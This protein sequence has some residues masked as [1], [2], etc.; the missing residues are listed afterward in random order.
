MRIK[1]PQPF[2]PQKQYNPSER[3]VYRGMVII[4]EAWNKKYLLRCHLCVI[5]ARE[6]FGHGCVCDEYHRTDKKRIYFRKL[7][8][9]KEKSDGKKRIYS[10]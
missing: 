5:Q 1:K 8:D 6:C 10:V 4:A 9:I 3:A 7:Y 2:D